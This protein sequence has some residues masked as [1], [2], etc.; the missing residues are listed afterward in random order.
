MSCKSLCYN[1]LCNFQTEKE[2]YKRPIPR[3][4]GGVAREFVSR[5]LPSGATTS[6][7]APSNVTPV[8]PSGHLSRIGEIIDKMRRCQV[9]CAPQK[10]WT[11]S[12]DYEFVAAHMENPE[13]FLQRCRDWFAANPLKAPP[14]TPSPPLVINQEPIVALFAKY[15]Q[16]ENG[17]KVP[18][19]AELEKAWRKAGYS[20]ERI[21][22]ALAWHAK[23]DAAS[24][25]RQKVL[26]VIFAKF[27]S[28]NKPAPK[29]KTK[30][31]IK[32]V[33]KKLSNT[34]NEQTTVG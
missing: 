8:I 3:S 29:T 22:K 34:S 20:E 30:K 18:P 5:T 2:M 1:T 33:K 24:D 21:T 28:A 14:T 17:P 6:Y 15:S 13:P 16:I 9:P 4:R 19:V 23:M 10:H 12:H 27:P 11:P 31:V 25:E 7:W 26:D 32:V